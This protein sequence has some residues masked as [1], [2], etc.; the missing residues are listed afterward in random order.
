MEDSPEARTLVSRTHC[1]V[2]HFPSRSNANPPTAAAAAAEGEE[3]ATTVAEYT[4]EGRPILLAPGC[5]AGYWGEGGPCCKA[6]FAMRHMLV[7]R[8][9]LFD[10]APIKWWGFADDDVYFVPG[11][12]R[13]FLGMHEANSST[14]LS[15][16]SSSSLSL[17]LS[18]SS[19][20]APRIVVSRG[21][22]AGS[23]TFGRLGTKGSKGH[24][25][26][27]PDFKVPMLQPALF[28]RAALLAMGPAV[29]D[30]HALTKT[31]AA[32]GITHDYALGILSWMHGLA[33][34]VKGKGK[35]NH[36]MA[37]GFNVRR[38]DDLLD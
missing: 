21:E 33:L 11:T 3:A 29:V 7:V 30:G 16:S 14:S 24:T 28:N 32:F 1:T 19:S 2:E 22:P 25:C 8:K 17:S 18:L 10:S 36:E 23:L 37:G 34:Q 38:G 12:M 27:N 26:S 4:C 13:R 6:Q 31:C 15:S 9:Q 20:V 35:F 5:D